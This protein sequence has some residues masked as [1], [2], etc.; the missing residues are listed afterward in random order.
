MMI[1]A[2]QQR[3]QQSTIRVNQGLPPECH[4]SQNDR[5]NKLKC[6]SFDKV[7]TNFNDVNGDKIIRRFTDRP[8]EKTY[9]VTTD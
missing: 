5:L 8:A 7:M 4:P 2:V 1:M 6:F 9:I 3:A